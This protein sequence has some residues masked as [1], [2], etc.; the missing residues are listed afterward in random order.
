MF[1]LFCAFFVNSRSFWF[2]AIVILA[3]LYYGCRYRRHYLIEIAK[4][5]YMM[6][7]L[8]LAIIFRTSQCSAYFKYL[9]ILRRANQNAKSRESAYLLIPHI[10]D[11]LISASE[12]CY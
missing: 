4:Q 3:K 7:A 2:V 11:M 9:D 12:R 1:K 6:G 5:R 8:L 10:R